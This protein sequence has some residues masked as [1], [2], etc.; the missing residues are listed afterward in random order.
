MDNLKCILLVEDEPIIALACSRRIETWGYRVET[1]VTGEEAVR[2][3]SGNQPPDLILMDIDLG[4][5]MNGAEAA[6]AILSAN[7]LPIVFLTS[8]AEREMVERVKGITRYG[9]VIKDS[10]DFVLRSSIEMAFEQIG[11]A[12]CRERV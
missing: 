5:G 1:A 9:Y 8:H 3:A 12:S 2:K 4:A 11:R 7:K 10:G 6:T